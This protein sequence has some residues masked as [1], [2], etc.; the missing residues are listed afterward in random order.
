MKV[1]KDRIP[2]GL[3][4]EK[5]TMAEF[6]ELMDATQPRPTQEAM[7]KHLVHQSWLQLQ[8][9]RQAGDEPQAIK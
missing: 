4:P 1:K 5:Q 2:L 6:N 9:A 3:K 8:K 7:F